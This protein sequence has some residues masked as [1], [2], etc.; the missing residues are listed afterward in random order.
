MPSAH[1]LE[2]SDV[3]DSNIPNKQLPYNPSTKDFNPR[4][5]PNM[6][7]LLPNPTLYHNNKYN[8]NFNPKF[9]ND[10]FAGNLDS[11]NAPKRILIG[12]NHNTG[13]DPRLSPDSRD[14]GVSNR[15]GTNTLP[16]DLRQSQDQRLFIDI[17]QDHGLS[18]QKLR[19]DSIMPNPRILNN[20]KI[21]SSSND[22]R[23][24]ND[25][26]FGNDQRLL[27]D[28]RLNSGQRLKIDPRIGKTEPRLSPNDQLSPN[29]KL[30][31]DPRIIN[32]PRKS[33]DPRLKTDSKVSVDPRKSTNSKISDPRKP[34][35]PSQSYSDPRTAESKSFN[36]PRMA[37]RPTFQDN[38]RP[39]Q[40][41]RSS[42]TQ[43]VSDIG[44]ATASNSDVASL[45]DAKLTAEK[46]CKPQFA[47]EPDCRDESLVPVIDASYDNEGMRVAYVMTKYSV[48]M[49]APVTCMTP[50]LSEYDP[51]IRRH[52][53]GESLPPPLI[54]RMLHKEQK[55][56]PIPLTG[57]MVKTIRS[58]MNREKKTASM[59]IP[60]PEA[61][62][63]PPEDINFMKKQDHHSADESNNY[64]NTPVSNTSVSLTNIN[65][66]ELKYFHNTYITIFS[67]I[68]FCYLYIYIINSQSFY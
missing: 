14:T 33:S 50:N 45:I 20:L 16:N 11:R 46:M 68:I 32:D 39:P 19:S 21:D 53:M 15:I 56:R 58:S 5:Q 64:V 8:M 59:P 3:R 28:P 31:K 57:A 9:P 37:I 1:Q 40:D 54:Q 35:E 4:F 36:D 6:K 10:M 34:F 24:G 65:T 2:Q 43:A 51:R 49:K 63:K 27:Q 18:D 30:S 29:I 44:I 47:D 42:A 13:F 41:P 26:R 25:P 12:K 67:I 23:Y 61:L 7:T 52:I 55:D 60:L 62:T 38:A 48:Q 22:P 17:K 66:L